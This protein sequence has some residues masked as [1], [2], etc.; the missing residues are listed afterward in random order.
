M[1]PSSKGMPVGNHV[2]RKLAAL[3]AAPALA[4][5]LAGALVGCGATDLSVTEN[6]DRTPLEAQ[7]AGDGIAANAPSSGTQTAQSAAAAYSA[8]VTTAQLRAEVLP[9][10]AGTPYVEVDAGEPSFSADEATTVAFED[11]GPLDELGRCTYAFACLGPETLATGPREDIRSVR[12]T[13]WR[14]DEYDFVDGLRLY[15]RCH[16]IARQLSDENANERNLITGTRYLNTEGMLE[17]EE[18]TGD[19]IRRTG[20]HVLYR[21]TPLFLGDELVARGVQMEAMSMEDGG[22]GISFNIYAFNVQPGVEIDYATGRNWL[23]QDTPAA[24]AGATATDANPA[25]TT[26]TAADTT[27]P[28]ADVSTS[29]SAVDYVLNT[30]SMKFHLPSCDNI[31]AISANNRLDVHMTRD[32]VVAMGYAPCGGCQP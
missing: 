1:H 17:L 4:A 8:G 30:K 23:A 2:M 29:A 32:E 26:A 5:V 24:P 28:D 14:T 13:G 7:V 3:L 25:G 15:N 27:A 9:S 19:Y 16:L 20:N 11:Y 12:P 6:P 31:G 10:F 21:V 22:A 18:M